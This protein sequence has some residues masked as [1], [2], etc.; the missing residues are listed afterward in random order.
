MVLYRHRSHAAEENFSSTFGTIGAD[1]HNT[2]LNQVAFKRV[3]VGSKSILMNAHKA[4]GRKNAIRIIYSLTI[5]LL[6]V[7]VLHVYRD[8]P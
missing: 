6:L 7:C 8:L 4:H 5:S 2:S 1:S 3:N